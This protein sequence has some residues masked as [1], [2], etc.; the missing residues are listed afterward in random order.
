MHMHMQH[1]VNFD[2]HWTGSK[3]NGVVAKP[4]RMQPMQPSREQ[5]LQQRRATAAQPRPSPSD[6][7][8]EAA[9]PQ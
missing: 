7:K 3:R 5:V 6:D 9:A 4:G 1:R 8:Q 2:A